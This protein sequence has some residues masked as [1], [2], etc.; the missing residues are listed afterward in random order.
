VYGSLAGPQAPR[1]MAFG[2]D[3]SISV[4][5]NKAIVRITPGTFQHEKL[6]D[7]PVPAH[8]GIALVGG[9]LYFAS[10]AELWSYGLESE[11]PQD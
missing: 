8:A 10:G 6:A 9:R 3:G 4:L 11:G 7:I 1:V 5:F 2:P